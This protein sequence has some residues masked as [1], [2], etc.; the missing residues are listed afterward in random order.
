MTA[1]AVLDGYGSA[2][3]AYA[4]PR[5]DLRERETEEEQ[6]AWVIVLGFVALAVVSIYAFYCT[7]SGGSFYVNFSWT[8]GFTVACYS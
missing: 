4:A 6:V 8:Q 1:L 7:A 3:M 2:G 5:I